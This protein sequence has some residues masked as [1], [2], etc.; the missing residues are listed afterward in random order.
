MA[1]VQPIISPSTRSITLQD[2][3]KMKK[4]RRDKVILDEA[5]ILSIYDHTKLD[6]DAMINY[7][8]LWRGKMQK[9]KIGS[10]V[11]TSIIRCEG[12]LIKNCSRCT[13]QWQ[14]SND[15]SIK[16]TCKIG[17]CTWYWC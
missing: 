16:F 15:W 12:N 9:R 2:K 5:I 8:E 10:E 7:G 3:K 4:S 17:K 6:S 14:T 13:S 11:Q 1:L